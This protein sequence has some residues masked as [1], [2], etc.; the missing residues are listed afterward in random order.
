MKKV[1]II[2]NYDSFTHILKQ[3]VGELKG[4]P[5]VFLNDKITLSQIKKMQPS[6]IIL[7]PGPGTVNHKKD[8]G[9]MIEVI[10][11]FYKK[12][13]IL[14]ICLGHQAIG[15]FF[16]GQIVLAPEPVHGKRCRIFHYGGG[17]FKGIKNPLNVMRYHSL[18]LET[19]F[20]LRN[21]D[22]EVTTHSSDFLI[23]GIKHKE[24]PLYGVQFHPE[25]LGTEQGKRIVK[26]FL[27]VT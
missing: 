21:K 24:Y 20:W 19:S 5:I 7:S 6:H 27:D 14:G 11:N 15:K 10:E 25:S 1:L 18:V 26:N 13:P 12:I 16:G 9:I 8:R 3:Y 4:N 23:M 22:I 2:D 17:L